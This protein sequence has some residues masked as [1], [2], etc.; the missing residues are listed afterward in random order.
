MKILFVNKFYYLKG[1]A[2]RYYFD[3]KNLFEREGHKVIPFSMEDKKNFKSDYSK[4]FV[5]NVELEKPGFSLKDLKTA[6]RI[7]YS[8][9]A[10]KKIEELIKKEKPEIAHIN[11]IYHQ[12]SPSILTVLKKYKIPMVQTLHDYKLI[13]PIY[14]LYSK[15]G[16]CERCKKYRY[17]HCTFRKCTKN[18]RGASLINTKE[19]YWH[20]F[21]KIY[22][23]NIDLF[24]SPSNFLRNK[25]LEWGMIKPKKIIVLP[26]T[27]GGWE[28]AYAFALRR[29]IPTIFIGACPG[30]GGSSNANTMLLTLAP[31]RQGEGKRVRVGLRACFLK[32]ADTPCTRASALV[33]AGCRRPSPA[34]HGRG[35]SAAS[36]ADHSRGSV[37]DPA[38]RAAER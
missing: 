1:G 4:Y 11:N 18:S 38:C 35:W 3:L 9:E 31:P 17:Y 28:K 34:F 21:L 22:E 37:N 32:N 15:G 20:K 6:G 8:F 2:E 19:M 27:C 14:I 16:I 29:F 26:G 24:I 13:C 25:I 10:K 5:S 12:I 36:P 7:I 33:N 23:N 30:F